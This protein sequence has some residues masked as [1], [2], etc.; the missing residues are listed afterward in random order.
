MTITGMLHKFTMSY[1]GLQL[2]E[3]VPKT[4]GCH[5][6]E[7]DCLVHHGERSLKLCKMF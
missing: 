5:C 6:L 2:K 3:H 7:R 1:N 4:Q